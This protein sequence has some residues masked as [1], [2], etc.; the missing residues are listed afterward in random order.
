MAGPAKLLKLFQDQYGRK[1]AGM[2]GG[3][4]HIRSAGISFGDTAAL[5]GD[6][7]AVGAGVFGGDIT[8]DRTWWKGAN[9]KDRL[10]FLAHE[11]THVAGAGQGKSEERVE[12][13]ADA[14]RYALI[15][16]RG[17]WTASSTHEK[18]ADR[19]GWA[20]MAGPGSNNVGNVNSNKNTLLNQYSKRTPGAGS[21]A[22]P[23]PADPNSY[24][25]FASTVMG[26][27]QQLAAAQA[28]ARAGIG[29][30]RSQ[31]MIDR[32]AAQV[33]RV[34]GVTGAEADAVSR[35]VV[36][37]SADLAARGSAVAAAAAMR[38][39]AMATKHAAIAEARGNQMAAVGDFYTGMGA[40][41]A[42]LA[43]TQAMQN[44][45][46]FQS[47]AFDT[48]QT[49]FTALQKAMLRRLRSRGRARDIGKGG[50]G[51]TYTGINPVTGG[52]IYSQPYEPQP[53]PGSGGR[54]GRN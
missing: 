20:N 11:L 32:Q 27:Q 8:V 10:G 54:F 14:A 36:G 51:P 16:N 3:G 23:A 42:D 13:L 2:V 12:N 41:Q 37:G 53:I 4:Q 18:I 40:A 15:G 33:A 48:M 5:T 19:K 17:G 47:D 26:L 22:T 38:Q 39:Q 35:G 52:P 49:N 9:R 24:G 6:E 28:L 44:I 43:N 30:A 34:E 46:R 29:S 50:G 31:A 21:S 1:L 7:G 45:Q 25:A